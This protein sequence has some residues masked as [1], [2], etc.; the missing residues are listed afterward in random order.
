MPSQTVDQLLDESIAA[1]KQKD[2]DKVAKLIAQAIKLDAD[3]ERAWLWLSGIVATDSRGSSASNVFLQ[4]IQ[5]M[6][7][8]NMA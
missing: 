2:H 7:L 5:T 8:R 3:N 4:S 1:Y 6:R